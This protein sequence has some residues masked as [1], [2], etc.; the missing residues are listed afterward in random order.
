MTG[1]DLRRADELNEGTNDRFYL[2]FT[3]ARQERE[4]DRL[5]T[6]LEFRTKQRDGHAHEVKRLRA[7]VARLEAELFAVRHNNREAE[8][9]V[10]RLE[11]K[12]GKAR[13]ERDQYRG[14]AHDCSRDGHMVA[15]R[16]RPIP[17][18]IACEFIPFCEVCRLVAIPPPLTLVD[19]P[20]QKILEM[21]AAARTMTEAPP[22]AYDALFGD[23]D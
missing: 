20:A 22:E 10:A 11:R 1:A 14:R 19:W 16:I 8:K 15:V 13:N 12:L 5:R 17:G 2:C 23:E 7:E 9:Q 21:V 6:A 3:I 4:I 18:D